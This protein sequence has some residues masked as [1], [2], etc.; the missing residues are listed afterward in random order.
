MACD[1]CCEC[2]EYHVGGGS[3]GWL[4]G[5]STQLS[6]LGHRL[7]TARLRDKV[8]T[9]HALD[10]TLR[11][12]GSERHRNIAVMYTRSTVAAILCWLAC[13]GGTGLGGGLGLSGG[14]ASDRTNRI[15][16][17]SRG[18]YLCSVTH[19]PSC[20]RCSTP[21]AWPPPL[22]S[23]VCL[24]LCLEVVKIPA[25]PTSAR[26]HFVALTQIILMERASGL[27]ANNA[28]DCLPSFEVLFVAM[29][30]IGMQK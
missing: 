24:A 4:A 28:A 30:Y 25:L 15:R 26:R 14:V 12:D 10:R 18:Q 8:D 17:G 6:H 29:S 19:V 2:R 16:C 13:D 23:G 9:P 3:S 21:T 7:H 1:A 20:A 5:R 27:I 22:L 11:R